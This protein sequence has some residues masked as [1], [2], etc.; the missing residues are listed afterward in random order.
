MKHNKG[1]EEIDKSGPIL[2]PEFEAN[3]LLMIQRA[4]NHGENGI[5]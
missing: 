5:R 4:V 3:C 1:G 2:P